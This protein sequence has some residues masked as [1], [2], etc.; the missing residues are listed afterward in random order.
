MRVRRFLT[1][2]LV[3]ALFC[4]GLGAAVGGLLGAAVPESMPLF[5]R[6][7]RTAHGS[8]GASSAAAGAGAQDRERAYV[9][10]AAVGIGDPHSGTS[11]GLA[12]RGAAFGAA[13]GLMA[14]TLLGA[15]LGLVDQG[16]LLVR[17]GLALRPGAA[18]RP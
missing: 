1:V 8:E 14:G 4:A 2:V 15:L 9:H 6:S 12:G 17:E 5:V 3:A 13:L 11:P 18:S 10:S 16:V 7:H